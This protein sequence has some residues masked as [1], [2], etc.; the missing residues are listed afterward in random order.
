[1]EVAPRRRA[2][3]GDG[4][5]GGGATERGGVREVGEKRRGDGGGPDALPDLG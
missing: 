1:M 3:A 5:L 4:E 2:A